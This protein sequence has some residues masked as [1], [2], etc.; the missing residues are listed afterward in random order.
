L[1]YPVKVALRVTADHVTVTGLPPVIV[2]PPRGYAPAVKLKV[3][4]KADHGSIKLSLIT[5][6]QPGVKDR[7]LPASPQVILVHPTDFGTIALVLFAAVLALFVIA[8]AARAIR[9]GRPGPPDGA[10]GLEGSTKPPPPGE[11]AAPV[12]T[13]E[14]ARS[15]SDSAEP[16]MPADAPEPRDPIRDRPDP[17]PADVHAGNPRPAGSSGA[18]P[19]V[20]EPNDALV[21]GRAGPPETEEYERGGRR[22]S[23]SGWVAPPALPGERGAGAGIRAEGFPNAD[24][25]PEYADSVGKDRSELT[26]AGPSVGDQEPRRATE[27]RR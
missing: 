14:T 6:P 22:P 24:N 2:V 17:V 11:H 8:S 1:R 7:P 12:P 9:H 3:H 18:R 21:R 16:V 23:P 15:Q 13:G 5:P 27:E 10:N 26:S 20:A 19:G 25:E 4:V